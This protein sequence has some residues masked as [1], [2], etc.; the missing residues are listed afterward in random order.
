MSRT[1]GST[2]INRKNTKRMLRLRPVPM[3]CSVAITSAFAMHIRGDGAEVQQSVGNR[4]DRRINHC[5]DT[6]ASGFAGNI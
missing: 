3:I 1:S 2:D 4:S 5:H 6:N